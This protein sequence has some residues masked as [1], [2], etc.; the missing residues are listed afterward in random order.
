VTIPL[1]IDTP[2]ILVDVDVLD[3]NIE[4]M[5]RAVEAKGLALRPHAK[6]HKIPE[7]AARQLA[8]GAVGLTV[9]TIGE[10][11]VF[12]ARG[13]E[14][15]FIAYPLWISPQK[16]ERLQRL[17]STA[18]ISVGVD[19]PSGAATLGKGL[20]GTA[21]KVA[22]LIEIDSGHHRSGVRPGAA[23]A[24]ARAA[25][26]AGLRVAG[27]FTFPGHSYAPGMPAQAAGQEQAALK[28]AAEALADAGFEA[29]V[30]SGGS[31]PTALLTEAS[32]A[33]EV[34][35]GVYVFGDAQQFELGRCALDDISLTVAATV[36][37]HHDTPPGAP[38][39]FIVD[40]GSKILGSDRPA[41]ATGFGRLIDY[42]DARITALS[43]HHAT[44][45][46]H[47]RAPAPPIG[48]RLR[49]IPNHVCLAINLVDE[50][51]VVSQW[52]LVDRWSVA[53]RGKNK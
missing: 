9:A 25:S 15:I 6:T 35:P 40:A 13:V 3:R 5:A 2:E 46:W 50:V 37:S 39:R 45:E 32:T 33:T 44:V 21:G 43:E 23:T 22:V 36:V 42:E 34:R 19:S 14:D 53:A 8:A 29:Q 51:A 16:A 48:A 4:R 10:A 38:A 31:T 12:A 41:W 17:A 49:I 18:E 7:I 47:H 52:Q 26:E 28:Q 20:G 24:V 27:V 1:V 30:R 11:E